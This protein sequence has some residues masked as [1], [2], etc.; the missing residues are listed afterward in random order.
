MRFLTILIAILL[1]QNISLAQSIKLAGVLNS[2]FSKPSEIPA[3]KG[4]E[5]DYIIPQFIDFIDTSKSDAINYPFKILYFLNK[6][7][8]ENHLKKVNEITFLSIY[9]NNISDGSITLTLEMSKTKESQYSS[10]YKFFTFVDKRTIRLNY[11]KEKKSWEYGAL[12]KVWDEP[13][14]GQN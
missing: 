3:L 13:A 12:I 5:I 9:Y 10:R 8:F 14:S 1:L 11:N 6:N 2:A 7:A 4:Q